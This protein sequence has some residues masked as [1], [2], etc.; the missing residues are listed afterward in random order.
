MAGTGR[1]GSELEAAGR[2]A[3]GGRRRPPGIG[4]PLGALLIFGCFSTDVASL[5]AGGRA[6]DSVLHT[7]A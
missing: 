3:C 1:M 6:L 2:E 5:W 7:K 4:Q